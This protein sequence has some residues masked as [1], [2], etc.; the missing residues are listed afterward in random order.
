[1]KKLF[2]FFAAALFATSLF[3]KEVTISPSDIT[4]A[5]N[6]EISATVNGVTLEIS[7]GTVTAE[8]IR[9]FKGKTITLSASSNITKIVFTCTANGT[10]KYGPGCFNAVEGYT[11]EADGKTGTWEGEAKSVSFTAETNQVRATEIVVVLSDGDTPE[12]PQPSLK[13]G[14]YLSGTFNDW[15][16]SEDYMF[17][18]NPATPG[19][20]MIDVTLA[21]GDELKGVIVVSG[22]EQWVGN[23]KDNDNNFKVD[24]E[25]AGDVTIYLNPAGNAA[26]EWTFIYIEVK[27]TP[28]TPQPQGG[29]ITITPE[30]CGWTATAGEQTGT[31][32]GVTVATTQGMASEGQDPNQMRAYKGKT[33]TVSADVNI[34]KIVITCTASGEEKYGPGCF[35]IPEGVGE[36]SYEDNVGTWVG[37]AK[38]VVFIAATNQVRMTSVVVTLEGG[39]TPQPQPKYEDGF[40]LVGDFTEWSLD[41]KGDYK[42]EANPNAEGEYMLEMFLVKGE[43]FKAVEVK[44]DEIVRWY[45]EGDGNNI[46]FDAAEEAA[47]VIYFRPAGNTAWDL[48]FFYIEV[49]ETPEPPQPQGDELWVETF[50]KNGTY[51]AKKNG[52]YWPYANEWFTGYPV[53]ETENVE[54]NQYTNDYSNVES[55]GVSIRS[56]KLNGAESAVP[57]LYFAMNKEAAKN[58]VKFI[59]EPLFDASDK[60]YEYTLNFTICLP[61]SA[62]GGDL[63]E[64]NIYMNGLGLALLPKDTKLGDKLVTTDVAVPLENMKINDLQFDFDNTATQKF[65]SKIWIT[66]EKT[67]D[68]P[69]PQLED[70]F[71]L[72]G[73]MNDWTPEAGM[74]FVPNQEVEGEYV[75]FWTGEAGAEMKVVKVEG[76]K[77]STWFPDGENNNFVVG[78]ELAGQLMTIHFNPAGVEGWTD[79]GGFCNVEIQGNPEPEAEFYIVGGFSDWQIA[80]DYK[81]I[82]DEP[83]GEY[84]LEMFLTEGEELKA[85]AVMQ[86][87]EIW[88]PEGVGNNWKVDAAHAG[89]V[90]IHFSTEEH[91]DWEFGYAYIE[92]LETPP[93]PQGG[94][95]TITPE[96]CGWTATAGEQSGTVQGVTVATSQGLAS[97]GQDPNQMR[98]YKGKTFTVSADVNIIKIV[99]TC[100]ASGE[101]KY[102]PGCFTIPEGVGEYS[103]EDNVG[104][105]V[106]KAKEVVFTAATNQVR[107]T[108]VVVTLEGGEEEKLA[109]GF[110]LAGDYNKWLP[111]PN[112]VFFLNEEVPELVEYMK[113]AY[114]NEGEGIKVVEY[115]NGE[116]ANWYPDGM[117]NEYKVDAAHAG[118]VDIYFRTEYQDDW[119]EFGGYM[120]ITEGQLTII[121]LDVEY[122]SAVYVNDDE[123]G[124]FWQLNLYKDY[125][126]ETQSVTYPDL[127]VGVTP[128]SATAIA[129]TYGASDIYFVELDL[130]ENTAIEAASISDVVVTYKEDGVYHFGFDF[131]GNDGIS[132]I[133]DVEVPVEAWDYATGEE[134][135][136]VEDE[137]PVVLADGYYL[138]GDFNK[139]T[140][141]ADYMFKANPEAEGEYMLDVTLAEGDELKG[142]I[143][144][145]GQIVQW[146]GN[147]KDGGNNFKV[148]AEHAGDVTIYLNPAGR[149]DWEWTYIYIEV[150]PQPEYL[151]CADVLEIA[152]TME[153]PTADNKYVYGEE[154]VVRAY[155]Q[156]AYD[157]KEQQASP[158]RKAL[159]QSVWLNDD[160]GAKSGQIQVY[161][162][163]VEEALAKG[164]YVEA[165]GQVVK[166]FKA[167]GNIIVELLNGE[168][169]K[170]SEIVTGVDNVETSVEVLK[171]IQNGQFIIIR[172]GQIYNAAGARI[173]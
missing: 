136:L 129:G 127:Y 69:Q 71:Y 15:A 74:M 83:S 19:E 84:L 120:Y 144:A 7:N 38:E 18:E 107:M 169:K 44:D 41:E 48:N 165:K 156:F 102:G 112:D 34:I 9:I 108:S 147:P 66:A 110:Y 130:D 10:T 14:Y 47:V 148:D 157:P 24:A 60:N 62:D 166:Y 20:Y 64:M 50:D 105:W 70:G 168:M 161:Y 155:V 141:S 123:L 82:L 3:A 45:P 36:Y 25:H 92:V 1:M 37:K 46:T 124:N 85:V 72:V 158:A 33:F 109:D 152:A 133:V 137:T 106:G 16:V 43:Q 159:Q 131:M 42:L 122:G 12:P 51:V 27:E 125:D 96:N 98:A 114:L 170:V 163:S 90:R 154:V 172:N 88:Y 75:A 54:G 89:A 5:E 81:L 164:D 100:T 173:Q 145:F 99:I 97:E 151:T 68:T 87:I 67:G 6:T 11:F 149:S 58:Y 140:V 61:E 28:P 128:K 35:T 119:A 91:S 31:V 22:A 121:T 8:Q 26:W 139:W 13:D 63:Q 49:K 59:G 103:Y 32:Q 150:H 153:D 104:T 23:P 39:E 57:G 126:S 115:K 56:K 118:E 132:Y 101:E 53:S 116:A 55:N 146:V 117:G 111:T 160:K 138:A 94:E 17:V 142:V 134:I 171:T 52:T 113:H 4:A 21:E 73:T 76:E 79:F 167:E 135:E 143:V 65:I 80:E 86:G 95:I 2:S 78:D 29:E 77:I 30:N 162:G 40:Y 93:S